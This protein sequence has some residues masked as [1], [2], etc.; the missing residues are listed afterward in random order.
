MNINKAII[1]IYNP[2]KYFFNLWLSFCSFYWSVITDLVWLL[3]KIRCSIS[4]DSFYTSNLYAP[5][6]DKQIYRVVITHFS[7]DFTFSH[8]Y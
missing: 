6:K 8:K 4:M 3:K 5:L 2:F 7:L 1:R